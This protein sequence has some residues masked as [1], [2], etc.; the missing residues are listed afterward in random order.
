M[1][2][3]TSRPHTPAYVPYKTSIRGIQVGT[4][5]HTSTEHVKKK[6]ESVDWVFL[7]AKYLSLHR[8]LNRALKEPRQSLNSVLIEPVVGPREEMHV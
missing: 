1:A 8:R 2:S 7:Q 3:Y 5:S 6:N 4:P